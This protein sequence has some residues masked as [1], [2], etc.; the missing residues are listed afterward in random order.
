VGVNKVINIPLSSPPFGMGVHPPP[1]PY[2]PLLY[3]R[4]SVR[5]DNPLYNDFKNFGKK[6][7]LF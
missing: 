3:V 6:L 7:S 2:P 5:G 1:L 4:M